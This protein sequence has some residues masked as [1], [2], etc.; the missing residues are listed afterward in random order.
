ML[1]DLGVEVGEITV[2]RCRIHPVQT[3]SQR[4][5]NVPTIVDI[6]GKSIPDPLQF[7]RDVVL[8]SRSDLVGKRRVGCVS[9]LGIR[10]IGDFGEVNAKS[11]GTDPVQVLRDSGNLGVRVGRGGRWHVG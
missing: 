5:D 10:Q 7:L 3:G 11:P 1:H 6:C 8:Q 4:F 2:N 9:G